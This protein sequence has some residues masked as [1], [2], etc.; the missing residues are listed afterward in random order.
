MLNET[1]KGF[2][3]RAVELSRQGM[4]QGNGGPF[5]CVIVLNGKI[6]GEGSNE[7]TSSNDPTAH[8][9]LVLVM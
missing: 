6:I 5:G 3:E 2:L 4:K 8:P 1:E 9:A 7:V